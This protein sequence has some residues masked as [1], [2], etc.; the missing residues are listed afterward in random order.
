LFSSCNAERTDD[1]LAECRLIVTG[2]DVQV[3]TGRDRIMS[4]LL[5]LGQTSFAFV[6]DLGRTVNEMQQEIATSGRKQ[7]GRAS[8]SQAAATHKT[9]RAG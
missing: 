3:A 9:R 5:S 2:S 1:L 7:S 6:F 4:A 8:A